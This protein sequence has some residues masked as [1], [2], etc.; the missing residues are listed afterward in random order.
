MADDRNEQIKK[1]PLLPPFAAWPEGV[2]GIAFTE[3]DGLGVSASG[4]LYWRG[5]PVEIRRP[6]DLSFWQKLAAVL[7][8]VFTVV[9][10]LGAAVQGWTAYNDWACKAT[11]RAVCAPA[12]GAIVPKPQLP[13]DLVGGGPKP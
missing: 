6:L 2:R 12:A 4:E 13:P 8:T 11:W 5:K 10:G 9:G 1:V 7:V 3:T